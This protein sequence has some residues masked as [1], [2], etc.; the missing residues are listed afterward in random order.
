MNCRIPLNLWRKRFLKRRPNWLGSHQRVAPKSC[1]GMSK[2]PLEQHQTILFQGL[3]HTVLVKDNIR[4]NIVEIKEKEIT[5]IY[6][7]YWIWWRWD[8]AVIRSSI[9]FYSSFAIVYCYFSLSFIFFSPSCFFQ[10][11]LQS[12]IWSF[13][14]SERLFLWLYLVLGR[15]I[16][17]EYNQRTRK[18]NWSPSMPGNV[19]CA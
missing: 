1:C 10:I 2:L 19:T 8:F 13:P 17:G 6:T 3:D 18:T 7:R 5:K 9:F 14:L 16:Y 12:N 11:F 4:D 15:Q